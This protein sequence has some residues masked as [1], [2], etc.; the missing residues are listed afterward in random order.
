MDTIRVGKEFEL[1]RHNLRVMAHARGIIDVNAAEAEKPLAAADGVRV[2][3]VPER[4]VAVM[5]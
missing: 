1:V 3:M 2:S 4:A 5:E